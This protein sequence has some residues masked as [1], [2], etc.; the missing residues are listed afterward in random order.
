[1]EEN[2]VTLRREESFGYL[3]S[4]GI[5]IRVI[6]SKLPDLDRDNIQREVYN[7]CKNI[8][9]EIKS[10]IIELDPKTPQEKV[11]NAQLTKLFDSPIFVEEIPNEYCSDWCCRHLPWFIVTTT[12][13]RFKI[14]WR[15]RVISIN[16][17]D[18]IN[19]KTAEELF[20]DEDVTKGE[21]SIHAW[22]EDKAQ[23][24]IKKIFNILN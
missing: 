21:K 18:T 3:G 5:E 17:E 22:S 16:W 2:W 15:K 4:L 7:A 1:M 13:G 11:K 12:I 10:T 14:G 9:N 20:P 23:E 19:T 24:Y 6:G 8:Q